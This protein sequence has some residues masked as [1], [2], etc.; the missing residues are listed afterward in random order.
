[1]L[2]LCSACGKSEGGVRS[3]ETGVA[4]CEL[5]DVGA[6]IETMPSARALKGWAVSVTKVF[7]FI[8][9]NLTNE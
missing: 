9:Q 2:G 3:L 4:A 6:R 8:L 1:M 7:L 5:S